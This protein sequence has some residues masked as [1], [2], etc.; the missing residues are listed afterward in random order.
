MADPGNDRTLFEQ[1]ARDML[2]ERRRARRWSVFFKLLTFGIVLVALLAAAAATRS[3]DRTCLDKC[4]ALVELRGE[5][6]A[7]GRAGAD[8][9][10]AGLQ[11]AFT[12]GGVAGVILRIN[13]PGGS[14]VQAG[15][16]YDEVKRLRAAH[17]KTRLVAVVDEMAASGGYYVAAAAD[18]I[19]V[20]K[21]SIV[22]SI[23]VIMDGFGF[24]GALEK[25]GVER[26]VVTAGENKAF[27][28]PFSP[29]DPKQRAYVQQ[30]L[31]EIHTQFIDAVKA[32]RGDRL[33]EMPGM[34]SGLVWHGAKAIELG[35][36][37]KLGNAEAVARDVFEAEEIVDFTPEDNLA[38]RVARRFGAT[39]AG[40]LGI[41]LRQ[42]GSGVR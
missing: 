31:D 24:P 18:E 19:Y 8:R 10:N 26:R 21:A 29:V 9:I 25:L 7:G 14:P 36:A 27:M 41:A 28:D 2:D 33:H 15:Q 34:F 20:D 3:H 6:E 39:L 30:M 23:G 16:I 32:G 17:P 11:A 4:T 35:L 37:D 42:G 40:Q 1:L 12:H 5:L 38:E 22:G 13:S